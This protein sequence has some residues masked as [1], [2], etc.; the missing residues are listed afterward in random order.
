MRKPSVGY[1]LLSALLAT[2]PLALSAGPGPR[3]LAPPPPPP[4]P[5]AHGPAAAAAD[6]DGPSLQTPRQEGIQEGR[7]LR[8]NGQPQ[9]AAWRWAGPTDAPPRQLWLPLE[10]LQG[11]L[12]FSSRTRLDGALELEWFGQRQIVPAARQIS[13]GDEVA[14]DV[15]PFLAPGGLTARVDQDELQ[16]QVPLPLLR[17]VRASAAPPGSRRVVLDLSGP[18]VVRGG[19][20]RIWLA[21][22][23]PPS[24]TQDLRRLGL[25]GQR[26]GDGWALRASAPPLRVFTLGEP[27]RVVID[28]AAAGGSEPATGVS[29]TREV[30]DPRLRALLGSELQWRQ[31]I[32]ES[33]GRRLR[34][35][36]VRMDPLS[37]S[38]ELRSL[39][40][41]ASMEGLTTLPL[42]A[43]RYDA[44]VAV[45]GGY[46]NR[47]RRLPLGALREQG[48]WLS[49]P[50][51]NRGV[52]AWEPSALPRFGRLDLR[53][54]VSDGRGQ[55]WPVWV[56]NSGYVRSG[57]ARYTTEWGSQYRALSGSEQAVLLRDGVVQRRYDSASLAAGVPL[58]REEELLV[59][60]GGAPLPWGEGTRLQLVSQASSDLGR[61]TNVVGGGPL[62]L[63]EGR[64]VLDGLAEGFSPAFLRQGAP[65]TVI[66]S[67][68]RHL[69]LLTLQGLE[70]EGPTLYETAQVLRAAGLRDALNLDGG[71]STGLVMGGLHTVKGR[72]VV[73]AVHNGLGLVPKTAPSGGGSAR[74]TA[75]VNGGEA[76]GAAT[77][78]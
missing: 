5:T 6:D 50:I 14:I 9:Q 51:L 42:L 45:N 66:G 28:W 29:P 44:L 26:E 58:G 78:S 59:A 24:I 34:L 71:S 10:V 4:A 52:V 31:E 39:S 36:S 8:V 23:V 56:V 13:L 55:P 25:S 2:W 74:P 32:V 17:T 21:A 46:F 64:I 48:R 37:S 1:G 41:G 61:A 53:E 76:S 75:P 33:G 77:G 11:Q 68:G 7:G 49:G 15:E 43:R 20:G 67:D 65:R 38:L 18:A 60:R 40:R 69:W 63:Q 12:G 35:N 22:Q 54:S 72:G 19:D 47:V 70:D 3:H 16:L 57:L 73:S 30:L 27:A 62:L